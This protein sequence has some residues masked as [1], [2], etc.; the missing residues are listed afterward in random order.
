V[1]RPGKVL[2]LIKQVHFFFLNDLEAKL[3]TKTDTLFE[4]IKIL[5]PYSLDRA[6]LVTVGG[7]SNLYS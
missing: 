5:K 4:A 2:N 7:G 6:I 3:I 1:K